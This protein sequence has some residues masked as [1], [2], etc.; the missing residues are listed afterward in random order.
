MLF[1]CA[2]L[3]RNSVQLFFGGGGWGGISALGEF[4]EEGIRGFASS[5]VE[6]VKGK[7]TA[8]GILWSPTLAAKGAARVGRPLWWLEE[9]GLKPD[10]TTGPPVDSDSSIPY[11]YSSL[12][13]FRYFR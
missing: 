10:R 13:L 4:A 2:L 12:F 9:E 5:A 7:A 3:V 11:P 6:P 8:G 1:Y